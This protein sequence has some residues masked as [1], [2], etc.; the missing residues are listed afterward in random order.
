[1]DIKATPEKGELEGELDAAFL[2]WQGDGRLILPTIHDQEREE[3]ER[4]IVAQVLG[5]QFD[6]IPEVFDPSLLVKNPVLFSM[7]QRRHAAKGHLEGPGSSHR[8][9]TRKTN[10]GENGERKLTW[11]SADPQ[12]YIFFPRLGAEIQD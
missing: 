5:E 10:N 2:L 11:S 12:R 6:F 4:R 9:R 8:P 3:H 7:H 1:M